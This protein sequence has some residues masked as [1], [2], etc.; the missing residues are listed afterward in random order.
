ME[1]ASG[2]ALQAIHCVLQ[3]FQLLGLCAVT[4]GATAIALGGGGNAN[5]S[6][7]CAHHLQLAELC[8]NRYAKGLL[9]FAGVFA[10][11]FNQCQHFRR[12]GIPWLARFMAAELRH[13]GT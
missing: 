4:A 6:Q 7:Q 11:H 13:K 12:G 10:G 3:Y 1:Q 9:H 8:R 5:S 2:P